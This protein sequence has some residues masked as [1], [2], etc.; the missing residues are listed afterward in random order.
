MQAI[1]DFIESGENM[2]KYYI[3]IL[4]G[5][6][7]GDYVEGKEV[8]GDGIPVCADLAVAKWFDSPDELNKWAKEN[9]SLNLEEGEYAIYGVYYPELKEEVV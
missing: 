8:P 2:W 5:S 7:T 6:C 4:T 1:L 9:T 3:E